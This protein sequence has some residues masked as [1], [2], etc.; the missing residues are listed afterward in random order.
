V[1]VTGECRN[2]R[3]TLRALHTLSPDLVFLDIQMPQLD[4]FEVLRAHPMMPPPV[5][6]GYMWSLTL[7]Y[8]VTAAVIVALYFPCRWFADLKARRKDVWLSYL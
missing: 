5:P 7:L 8:L 2:G 1:I 6:A 4:G 3:E